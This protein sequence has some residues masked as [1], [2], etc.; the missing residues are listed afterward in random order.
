MEHC[1]VHRIDKVPAGLQFLHG[2][3]LLLLLLV[4]LEEHPVGELHVVGA[5]L[6]LPLIHPAVSEGRGES[7]PV[8]S[9]VDEVEEGR[10]QGQG[11]HGDG[12]DG[13]GE[14]VDGCVVNLVLSPAPWLPSSHRLTPEASEAWRTEAPRDL[15]LSLLVVSSEGAP[16]KTG[17]LMPEIYQ[18]AVLAGVPGRAGA[19][20]VA[21]TEPA[22]LTGGIPAQTLALPSLLTAGPGV[23]GRTDTDTLPGLSVSPPPS[24]AVG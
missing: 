10:H 11:D 4:I 24:T 12:N 16:V 1:L 14:G 15:L 3:S 5:A 17:V 8:N 23:G 2:E 13:D 20:L 7:P 22:V 9:E 21:G 18:L 6:A 19:G